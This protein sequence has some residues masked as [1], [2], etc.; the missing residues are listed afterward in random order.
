[1]STQAIEY[2]NAEIVLPP[3]VKKQIWNGTEFVTFLMYRKKSASSYEQREWLRNTY[4]RSGVYEYGR[5]WNYSAGG[6]ITYMDDKV[7]MFY[8]MKWGAE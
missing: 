8:T 6:D 2:V 1:M 7:Y 5:F 3:P 4:G